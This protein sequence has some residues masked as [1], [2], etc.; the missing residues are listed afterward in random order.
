MADVSMVALCAMVIC[1]IATLYPAHQAS[2]FNPVEAIRY[3]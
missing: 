1:Y 3:G 2:R